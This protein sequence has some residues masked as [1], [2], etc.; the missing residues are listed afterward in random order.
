[1][2]LPLRRWHRDPLLQFLA[3]GPEPV[4]DR[5]ESPEKPR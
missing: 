3:L 1:M 2:T 4:E 5:F